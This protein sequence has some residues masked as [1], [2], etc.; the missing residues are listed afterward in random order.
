MCVECRSDSEYA[1]RPVAL[2]WRDQRL[3]I[4]EI[5]SRWRTPSGKGFRVRTPDDQV[6]VLTYDEISAD[7]QIQQP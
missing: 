2:Q 3:E 6:F 1:E 4:V 7:W 5:L